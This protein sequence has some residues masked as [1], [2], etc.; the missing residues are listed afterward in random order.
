MAAF[1]LDAL[2]GRYSLKIECRTRRAYSFHP[3]TTGNGL[4]VTFLSFCHFQGP[5]R[6]LGTK[7]V[8]T[9]NFVNKIQMHD[10]PF[11]HYSLLVGHNFSLFHGIHGDTIL[12]FVRP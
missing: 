8:K 2:S 4:L 7:R 9:S 12:L 3:K 11:S 1:R 6:V 5:K 10:V